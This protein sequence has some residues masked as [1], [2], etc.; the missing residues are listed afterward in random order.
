[1]KP[2]DNNAEIFSYNNCENHAQ[3]PV[4]PTNRKNV[5]L[6]EHYNDEDFYLNLTDE[7]IT[8]LSWLTENILDAEY[9]VVDT[10]DFEPII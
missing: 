10:I 4:K 2:T 3:P 9:K 1:M 6:K 5:I 8:L 7:Q